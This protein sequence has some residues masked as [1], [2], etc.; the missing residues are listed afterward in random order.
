MPNT[1]SN[2][3]QCYFQQILKSLHVE[4]LYRS[5]HLWMTAKVECLNVCCFWKL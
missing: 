1:A 4:K 3:G 2:H 5:V